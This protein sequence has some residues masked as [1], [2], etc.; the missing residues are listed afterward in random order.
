M[1][2][3]QIS[4]A[5]LEG[6]GKQEKAIQDIRDEDGFHIPDNIGSHFFHKIS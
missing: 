3:Q 2:K 5:H 6:K 1:L 4:Y